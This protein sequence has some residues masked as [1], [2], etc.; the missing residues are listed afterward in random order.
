MT[1]TRG[2]DAH[3]AEIDIDAPPERAYDLLADVTRMGEWSPECVRCRWIS[4]PHRP[5]VGARFRGTS[6]NGRRRWSTVSTVS[7]AAPART[8]AFDVTYF[9]LPV[10]GWRYEFSP[11]ASGGTH[12]TESVEDRRGRLI[13]ALSPLITG[14]LDRGRRNTETMQ[15][16]LTRLKAAAE[17]PDPLIG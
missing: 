10:A 11:N 17:R 15:A 6:R 9:R 14:S 8:F 4:A 3:R 2:T 5:E 12:V 13:R 7:A 16:T 1:A